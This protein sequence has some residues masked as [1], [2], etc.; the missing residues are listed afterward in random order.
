MKRLLS[1]SALAVAFAS[2]PAAAVNTDGFDIPYVGVSGEFVSVDS[3]RENDDGIG[4]RVRLGFPLAYDNSALEISLFS[5][6]LERDLDGE[7]DYQAGIFV[8][9]V[10]DLAGLVGNLPVK[11]FLLAGAGMTEDDILAN[12]QD[13]VEQ[14]KGGKDKL[15]GFFVGQTMKAMQGKANPAVVNQILKDKL[16]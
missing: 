3:I 16:G 2:G 5:N 13:K 12:N 10:Y 7:D 14:Y 6:S 1:A 15:F 11:P 8:D 4:G 9:Y